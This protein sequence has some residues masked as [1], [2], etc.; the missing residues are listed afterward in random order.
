[1]SRIRRV[2]LFMVFAACLVVVCMLGLSAASNAHI[3]TDSFLT[4]G[5]DKLSVMADGVTFSLE[6]NDSTETFSSVFSASN[7]TEDNAIRFVLANE[8]GATHMTVRITYATASGN[9][10]ETQRIEIAPYS[11]PGLYLFRSEN[12]AEML[13]ISL[14]FSP[15]TEGDVTLHA[16]ETTRV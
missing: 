13:S 15:T 3:G 6:Q 8:S 9:A 11:V 16:M 5:G 14:S 2:S 4:S 12:V 10:T 7:K 1:M